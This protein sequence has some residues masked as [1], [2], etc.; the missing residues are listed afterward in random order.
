MSSTS[1]SR[2]GSP[3]LPCRPCDGNARLLAASSPLPGRQSLR[4]AWPA[5][6]LHWTRR[7]R[8]CRLARTT[9]GSG[10][11]TTAGARC[12]RAGCCA[13]TRS[14]SS[15]S[16][17]A[18]TWCWPFSTAAMARLASSA[19]LTYHWSV[20]HG[21]TTASPR[22]ACGTACVCG[23]IFSTR[24]S[25]S[26][27]ATMRFLATKRSSPRYFSRHRV[28]ELR[29]GV[30]DVDQ[31][32]LGVALVDLVIVEVV[33]R[34]DLHRA[35][36]L[37]GIGIF[38]GDD[39]DLAPDQRQHHR[40]ADEGLVAIVLG[41]TATAVSP[42][43]VSGRVVAT[44]MNSAIAQ[45]V[46]QRSIPWQVPTAGCRL[47]HLDH[48]RPR[49]RTARSGTQGPNGRGACPCRSAPRCRG[50]RRPSGRPWRGPRPW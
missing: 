10:A 40:L 9:P 17:S 2:F 32:D 46:L 41:C 25:A 49:G 44:T 43:M 13:S 6:P 3:V 20:S 31:P 21:S 11:P 33:R 37:L 30:E 39:G 38:V 4:V 1:S 45:V 47:L 35:R 7:R 5:R 18:R 29:L 24:S 26:R 48:V 22:C 14:R 15:P 42:S 8:S 27:S 50:R 16:S 28:V 19:A 34:R 12:T 23:S 36:A